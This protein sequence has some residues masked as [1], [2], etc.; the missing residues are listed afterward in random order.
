MGGGLHS[1]G[2]EEFIDAVGSS[3]DVHCHTLH[4]RTEDDFT[5][6]SRPRVSST[7]VHSFPG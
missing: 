3:E 7:H 1:G 6:K 2:K 5:S 4:L